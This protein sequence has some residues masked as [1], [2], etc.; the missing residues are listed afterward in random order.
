[1]KSYLI[2]LMIACSLSLPEFSPPTSLESQGKIALFFDDGWKNQYD[3]AFPILKELGFKATFAVITDYIGLDRGTIWARMNLTELKELQK[4]GMEIASHTKTHPHM[5]NLTHERLLDEI[6][7]SKKALTQ[8]GFN[9]K[10]FVYPHGEWN[11]TIIEYV[12][13]AGYTCARTI[14]HEA[15]TIENK[16]ANTRYHIGSWSITN[17][18][19]EDFKKILEYANEATVIVLTYHFIAD[20]GPKETST[21]IRNFYEQMKYLKERSFEVVLLSELFKPNEESP[22]N[23]PQLMIIAVGVLAA[24]CAIFAFKK[25]KRKRT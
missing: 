19:L 8:L 25:W 7:N 22:W 17:Q 20:N 4:N 9:V 5:L 24:A 10:T 21:P 14:K 15:Y 2:I 3:E 12:K 23:P 16:D 18:T 11:Q 13:E 1:M 6:A